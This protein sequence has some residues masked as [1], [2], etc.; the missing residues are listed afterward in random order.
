VVS[1]S[2]SVADSIGVGSSS[3]APADAVRRAERDASDAALRSGVQVRTVDDAAGHQEAADVLQEI[4]EHPDGAPLPPAMLRAFAFTG[5]YVGAAFEGDRIV[6]AAIGF[7]T[8]HDALHSHIAGVLP[9]HQGRSIGY[10]LKL[11]QRA[12]ALQRGLG[13]I[14]WTFDPLIRRNAHFNLVKLGASVAG[15]LPDFYGEMTDH[16]NAGDHSDRLLV[17]WDLCG[18]VPGRV[19][20]PSADAVTV[21]HAT[22]DDRPELAPAGG[23]EWILQ[24]PADV[25]RLRRTDPGLA[26]RWRSAFR[27]TVAQLLTGG[28][29]IVGLDAH[30]AYVIRKDPS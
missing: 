10:L 13:V 21:L 11:H 22:G 7:R 26:R 15:H 6:G 3:E 4:W 16:I 17:E 8:D 18:A 30:S 9:S 25:E 1:V 27:E 14:A 2:S 12:W 24:L 28:Q 5:N 20:S 29:R 19:V 23:S